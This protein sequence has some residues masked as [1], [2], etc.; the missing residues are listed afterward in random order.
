MS[1]L[2]QCCGNSRASL[3]CPRWVPTGEGHVV[4]TAG[5]T[6]QVSQQMGRLDEIGETLPVPFLLQN[7]IV[8]SFRLGVWPPGTAARAAAL[9]EAALSKDS[10]SHPSARTAALL[11]G[12][13]ARTTAVQVTA[14]P[15]ATCPCRAP[16]VSQAQHGWPR[17]PLTGPHWVLWSAVGRAQHG[18]GWDIP[19][20]RALPSPRWL[21]QAH[22]PGA[23]S[24]WM[25]RSFVLTLLPMFVDMALRDRVPQWA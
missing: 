21:P 3:L 5:L 10:Q 22:P 9:P 17:R 12:T 15:A 16:L 20:S 11:L 24:P 2:L 1:V 25:G 7:R 4:N 13:A 8:E 6:R 14:A 18:Y 23:R 19:Y